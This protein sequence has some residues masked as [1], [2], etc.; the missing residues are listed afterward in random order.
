MMMISKTARR[1]APTTTN[2][3]PLYFGKDSVTLNLM[4]DHVIATKS[5]TTK[6]EHIPT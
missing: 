5:C 3:G 6:T 4:L 1:I 2:A